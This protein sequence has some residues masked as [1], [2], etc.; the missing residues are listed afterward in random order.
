MPSGESVNAAVQDN[1][2]LWRGTTEAP[3]AVRWTDVEGAHEVPLAT[4]SP[5]AL[6]AMRTE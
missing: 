6:E 3:D 4:L 2:F 5:E 1:A